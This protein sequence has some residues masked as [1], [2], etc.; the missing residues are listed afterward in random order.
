MTL[1][2]RARLRRYQTAPCGRQA[3]PVSNATRK[4]GRNARQSPRTRH[5]SVASSSTTPRI[6]APG[7]RFG[8]QGRPQ[9]QAGD[10]GVPPAMPLLRPGLQEKGGREGVEHGEHDFEI[11]EARPLAAVR[12]KYPQ[13]GGDDT[14]APAEQA[15]TR[16]VHGQRATQVREEK[17]GARGVIV[18]AAG[19]QLRP[20]ELQRQILRVIANAV[21]DGAG[22]GVET[23]FIAVDP[24]RVVGGE[25][26]PGDA[27][28][29]RQQ[30][31]HDQ[32]QQKLLQAGQRSRA[33]LDGEGLAAFAPGQHKAGDRQRRG[34]RPVRAP[35]AG[36]RPCPAA[37]SRG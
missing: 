17:R 33:G 6:K 31:Q 30:R 16:Q 15:H 3:S 12:V 29:A 5:S 27:V 13:C 7:R 8:P 18:D 32:G 35:V 20:G 19:Q 1:W 9:Q 22:Q 25:G 11:A 26:P 36:C 4:R 24:Q 2:P 14:N 23:P 28:E 34:R 21:G 37:T 10:D